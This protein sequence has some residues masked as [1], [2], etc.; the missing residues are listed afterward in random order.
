LIVPGSFPYFRSP[1][2]LDHE[3]ADALLAWFQDGAPWKLQI[4]DFYEQYELSLLAT[5]IPEPIRLFI[6]P[7]FIDRV[8]VALVSHIGASGALE[9]IDIAAH[10]LVPNQTIRIHNDYIG[11]EE[12]HRFLIQV[13][14]GWSIENGGFLMLFRSG[15]PDDVE[16]VIEPTHRGGFGFRI[17]ENSFHAVSTIRKGDRFTLVYTFREMPTC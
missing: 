7:E 4:T 13:N 9:V 2:F 1:E 5:R 3:A 14:C 11:R 15:C 12:T 17:S 10:R 6:E 8:R 16:A